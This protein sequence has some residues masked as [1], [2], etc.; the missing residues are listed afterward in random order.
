MVKKTEL[1]NILRYKIAGAACPGALLCTEASLCRRLC[2]RRYCFASFTCILP[3]SDL[4]KMYTLPLNTVCL[5][6][7]QT[8]P[9]NFNIY[10]TIYCPINYCKHPLNFAS[11]FTHFISEFLISLLLLYVYIQINVFVWEGGSGGV[12]GCVLFVYKV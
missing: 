7:L 8:V 6:L 2:R 9:L 11:I 3:L 4:K 10:H 1:M 12:M 5:R